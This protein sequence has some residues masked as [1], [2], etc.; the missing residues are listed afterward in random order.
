M[1]F[2]GWLGTLRSM[3]RYFMRATRNDRQAQSVRKERLSDIP[4]GIWKPRLTD[5][6]W[7][8]NLDF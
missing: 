6:I 8:N 5:K 1:L 3:K 7:I 4:I 2:E